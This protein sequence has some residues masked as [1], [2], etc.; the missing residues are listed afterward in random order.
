MK[1]KIKE[2]KNI[3]LG[4][5][6]FLVVFSITKLAGITIEVGSLLII[7]FLILIYFEIIDLNKQDGKDA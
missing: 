3:L 5:A 2:I 6:G 4:I 7:L 1:N